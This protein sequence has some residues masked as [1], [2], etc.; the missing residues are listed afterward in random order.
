MSVEG[1]LRR[2]EGLARPPVYAGQDFLLALT[3]PSLQT[4]VLPWQWLIPPLLP[5]HGVF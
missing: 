1:T 3:D 5:L 2:P 4:K